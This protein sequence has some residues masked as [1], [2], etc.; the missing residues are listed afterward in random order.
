MGHKRA[1]ILCRPKTTVSQ[2][3]AGPHC[4]GSRTVSPA[5]VAG[6]PVWHNSVDRLLDGEYRLG[7][8]SSMSNS[9]H[10]FKPA[11]WQTAA[12]TGTPSA[13][14]YR[15]LARGLVTILVALSLLFIALRARGENVP[16]F[17]GNLRHTG[18][19]DG[20]GLTQFS[21]VKW[22]FHTP[23]EVV[24]SPAVDGNTV[25]VGSSGGN[26]Y[27]V[28]RESGALKWKFEV[29]NRVASS[30]AVAGGIVYFGAYDGF[31]YA[32][33][34]AT[35]QQKWKFQT[36]GERRYTARNLHGMQPSIETRPDP[37]DSYLSS[38]AVWNGAV[39]FGSGDGNVYALDAATGSLKWR[40]QTGDVVHASPAIADGMVFIGSWDSFFYALDAATGAEKWRYKTGDDPATHNQVGIQS[41]AAVVDGVVYFGCRDSHLYALDEFT[42]EKKWADSTNQ[43]WVLNSPAV[44]DGKVYFAISYGG[45]LYAADAKTGA[46]LYTIDFKGWPIYSSPSITG[47]TLYVGSTGGTM[48]AVDLKSRKLAWTFET[49]AAKQN[50][51]AFTK[52]DGTS[53]YFGAF[54]G[55]DFFFYDD[56]I[57][58]YYKMLAIGPIISSPVVAGDVLYFGSGDG[59]LY[60]L[61]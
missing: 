41:S 20:A 12:R 34:A 32:V 43:S 3:R 50:G 37:W 38:P 51:L 29:K 24:S 22:T 8:Q 19:Y 59:N 35:G 9:M 14:S 47:T 1:S 27:A 2:N 57:V 23:G 17:R 16:M 54:G 5:G 25:Y 39:Y 36:G 53:N 45:L 49:P 4:S 33:D 7:M 40:Y 46:I 11:P 26:L 60:A 42:G 30:P 56:V 44:S 6:Y 21:R 31:F 13:N 61:M 55:P 28:D 18:V 48:N 10:P 58:G 15:R 52:P